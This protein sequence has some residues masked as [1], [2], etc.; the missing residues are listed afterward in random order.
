VEQAAGKSFPAR[1]FIHSHQGNPGSIGELPEFDRAGSRLGS[2][3]VNRA[4]RTRKE[5]RKKKALLTR[6]LKHTKREYTSPVVF[7]AKDRE[8]RLSPERRQH[9][10]AEFRKLA[11]QRSARSRRVT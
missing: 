7:I 1:F 8:K 11:R 6:V 2:L 4:K 9:L 3:R 5:N 10:G